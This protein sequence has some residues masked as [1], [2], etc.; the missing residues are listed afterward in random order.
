M[1]PLNGILLKKTLSFF[2]FGNSIIKWFNVLYKDIVS[3]IQN[4]GH[5]SPFFSIQRGVREG[6]PLSPYLFILSVELLSAALKNNPNI[7]GIKINNS[8]YLISQYADDST[9]TLEDDEI[10]INSAL[11]SIEN[12]AKCS[13]LKVQHPSGMNR[14][15]L[16]S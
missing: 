4:N 13:G 15:L 11:I 9:L 3:C 10:S 7:K 16:P 6:D 1:I 12:V 5:L 14:Q 8:E 2:G